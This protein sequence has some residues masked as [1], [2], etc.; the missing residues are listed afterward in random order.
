MRSS[1]FYISVE[2]GSEN[3]KSPCGQ[4]HNCGSR[5]LSVSLSVHNMRTSRILFVRLPPLSNMQQWKTS[6]CIS[7]A[8][9]NP[10]D[11]IRTA[12]SRRWSSDEPLPLV[13]SRKKLQT[14]PH[15]QFLYSHSSVLAA[16]SAAGPAKTLELLSIRAPCFT[17]VQVGLQSGSAVQSKLPSTA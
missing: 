7:L 2:A 10:P 13:G 1:V 14:A 3:N 4:R 12:I 15:S 6:E 17:A 9:F 16:I 5:P 11:L 8:I